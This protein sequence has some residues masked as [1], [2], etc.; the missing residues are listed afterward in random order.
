MV[1]RVGCLYTTADHWRR[2]D[3]VEGLAADQALAAGLKGGAH[4]ASADSAH[5]EGHA[6]QGDTKTSAQ[7]AAKSEHVVS[8]F[9]AS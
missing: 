1:P 3:L 5:G 7:R 2:K 8:T 9:F 4:E 6:L